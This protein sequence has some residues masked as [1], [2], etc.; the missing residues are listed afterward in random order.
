MGPAG[1]LAI[2]LSGQERYL[3]IR[4]RRGVMLK[5]VVGWQFK[6]IGAR[7][8]AGFGIVLALMLLMLLVAVVQLWRIQELSTQSSRHT[9]RLVQVQEWSALVRTNLDR[10]LTASRL[11]AAL[12]EDE[13]VRARLSPVISK[14]NESMAATANA[15]VDLQKRV[16]AMTDEFAIATQISK[17]NTS[18]E[19]FVS[20]RAQVRDDI[21]MGEGGKRIDAE[22]VPLADSLLK[23]LDELVASLKARSA[24][25]DQGV[26]ET[27]QG[28]RVLLVAI[29]LLAL[30]VGAVIAWLT[31]RAITSP[32]RDAVSIAEN[33]AH[34]DLTH[35]F[36]TDRPDEIGSMLRR[37]SLMQQKL[38]AA[39]SDISHSTSLIQSASAEVATGN[40]DL[41]Q[42][43]EQAASNLQETASSMEQLTGSV[44]QSTESARSAS[45]MAASAA[46]VAQKGGQVVAEVVSTMN[47]INDSSSKIANIITVIDGIAFQTNIL[48]LNAAV[49]A[50]RAGEQGRGFAVVASEVRSLAQRSAEAAHEIKALIDTS[51]D[52]VG[53][54]ARLV[55]DA[56]STM[57]E[58]VASVRRVTETIASISTS[59]NEQSQ[60]IGQVNSAVTHLDQMTQQNAALVEESTAAAESLKDQAQKL[61]SIVATFR[62]D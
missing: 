15:T 38:H 25:A 1:M 36:E 11:D 54:G 43:T 10:A 21:Q 4:N 2:A 55:K 22:L 46:Q 52:N 16:L 56:G 35:N 13:A 53:A 45:Q 62:L 60:G 41:S 32:M 37:L 49:E 57:D 6:R 51:V 18:R 3:T 9:E 61:A 7:L 30:A 8:G 42:R 39:F 31:T 24:S 44:R 29:C 17:V 14:L 33:I 47:E 19:R 28:A 26:A 5:Q 40:A 59:A 12:G 48:A 27:V 23:S 20:I 50:A 58:I 34:G